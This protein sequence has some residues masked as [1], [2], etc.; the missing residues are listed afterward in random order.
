MKTIMT[1][2]SRPLRRA[3]CTLLFGIAALWAM[4][5][6]ARGQLYVSQGFNNGVG[7]YNTTTGAAINANCITRLR[8]PRGL[9]LA[10]NHRLVTNFLSKTRGKYNG[11]TG[12]E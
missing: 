8:A 5:R 7:K 3:L 4:P 1:S 10:G 11:A 6:S 2:N 12:A 9:A